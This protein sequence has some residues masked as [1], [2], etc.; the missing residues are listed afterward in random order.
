MISKRC[1]FW[2]R[3]RQ[4]QTATSVKV[5]VSVYY[6]GFKNYI[7]LTTENERCFQYNDLPIKSSCPINKTSKSSSTW[8]LITIILNS[9]WTATQK[10][11]Y[12][13]HSIKR[14]WLASLNRKPMHIEGNSV[15]ISTCR[16]LV[17]RHSTDTRP[18]YQSPVD[19]QSTAGL[20]IE[21]I[22]RQ[23]RKFYWYIA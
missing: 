4:R 19:R 7:L 11:K 16:S 21:T 2:Q 8:W 22:D 14:R 15:D 17:G 18:R 9:H 13:L 20:S 10:R 23:S 12:E 1:I 3:R 6:C 5:K